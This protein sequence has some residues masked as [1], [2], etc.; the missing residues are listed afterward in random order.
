MNIFPLIIFFF[1][2]LNIPESICAKKSTN[3]NQLPTYYYTQYKM[4][5]N[6]N[7][8]FNSPTMDKCSLQY[9]YESQI[10]PGFVELTHRIKKTDGQSCAD[11]HRD[12]DLLVTKP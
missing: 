3:K 6:C 11:F 8:N 10:Q 12:D 4:H 7:S 2:Q 9:K 1:E 5:N